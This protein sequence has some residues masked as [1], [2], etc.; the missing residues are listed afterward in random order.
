MP[1]R[2]EPGVNNSL[3]PLILEVVNNQIRSNEPPETRQTF[4]RLQTE[5]FTKEEAKELIAAVVASELYDVM[6][7][8]QPFNRDRFVAALNRLP[9]LPWE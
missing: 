6:K 3:K 5:G 1:R 2:K 4:E 7:E 8:Q 9:K